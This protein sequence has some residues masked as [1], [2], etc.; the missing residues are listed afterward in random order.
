MTFHRRRREEQ[1]FKATETD[2]DAVARGLLKHGGLEWRNPEWHYSTPMHMCGRSN[3]WKVL[4][5]LLLAK[6]DV[7][8]RDKEGKTVFQIACENQND[9]VVHLIQKMRLENPV[10][11]QLFAFVRDKKL[12]YVKKL[13]LKEVPPDLNSRH[14]EMQLTPL[15]IAAERNSLQ[16]LL[17]LLEQK[18]DP[19]L[20][21]KVGNTPLHIA[22][23]NNNNECVAHL[24]A[25]KASL[26]STNRWQ[27]TPLHTAAE[28]NNEN[29]ARQMLRLG[30]SR[31]C[32]NSDGM[33][34]EEFAKKFKSHE[35]HQL[36]VNT[37]ARENERDKLFEI[38]AVSTS[39]VAAVAVAKSRC[40]TA[41]D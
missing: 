3:A 9:R 38:C 34:P 2:D 29:A 41:R 5:V 32:H 10:E 20:A 17:F 30:A 37:N 12:G 35:V 21:D 18:A 11:N 36:I 22:T 31:E 13:L 14:T 6:A 40:S 26:E 27:H 15:H 25:S 23:K 4:K 19:D 1:L 16:C 24:L 8:M 7:D 39:I 33:I 28:H